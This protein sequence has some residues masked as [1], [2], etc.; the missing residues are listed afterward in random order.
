MFFVL[1]VVSYRMIRGG[2]EVENRYTPLIIV[3]HVQHEDEDAPAPPTYTYAD[4]KAD[5]KV[6]DAEVADANVVD[7][8]APE[9]PSA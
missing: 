9:Q 8:A 1:A 5:A 7:A 2:Q 3:E 4:E 6:A